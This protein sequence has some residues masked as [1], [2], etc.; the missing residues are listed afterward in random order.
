MTTGLCISGIDSYAVYKFDANRIFGLEG[1][2]V[3]MVSCVSRLA[4][5]VKPYCAGIFG[6]VCSVLKERCSKVR[7][8]DLTKKPSLAGR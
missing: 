3:C 4:T 2:E 5:R 8:K 1:C 6:L 7:W